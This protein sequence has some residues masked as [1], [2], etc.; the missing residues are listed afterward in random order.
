VTGTPLAAEQRP[1]FFKHATY[2]PKLDL[3]DDQH[4][5]LVEFEKG[6][7]ERHEKDRCAQP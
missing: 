7:A 1:L 3:T 2:V 5:R 4:A 6:R